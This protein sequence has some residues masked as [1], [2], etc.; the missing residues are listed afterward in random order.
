MAPLVAVFSSCWMVVL[1]ALLALA[2]CTD[3]ECDQ[4]SCSVFKSM[5]GFD[6]S[7]PRHI[8]IVSRHARTVYKTWIVCSLFPNIVSCSGGEVMISP[9]FIAALKRMGVG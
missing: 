6:A 9:S 7:F 8:A 5:S 2:N 4:A 1:R 3:V